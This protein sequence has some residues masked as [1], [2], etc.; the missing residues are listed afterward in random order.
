MTSGITSLNDE[1]ILTIE[2]QKS[3]YVSVVLLSG[4]LGLRAV[5]TSLS[6]L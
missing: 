3:G 1:V 4:A 6:G 5:K 2:F